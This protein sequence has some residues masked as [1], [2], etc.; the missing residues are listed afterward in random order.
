MVATTLSRKISSPTRG[1][2]V[3]SATIREQYMQHPRDESR[4]QDHTASAWSGLAV[5]LWQKETGEH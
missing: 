4:D 3:Y 1:E 2:K 5:Q